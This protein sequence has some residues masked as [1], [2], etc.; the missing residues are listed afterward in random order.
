MFVI[1]LFAVTAMPPFGVFLSELQVIRAMGGEGRWVTMGLFLVS[2]LMAFVGMTRVVFGIVDG[3]T[4]VATKG[5]SER[6]RESLGVVLPPLILLI[7]SLG[8]GLWT[9]SV[10]H[11]TWIHAVS[12]LFPEVGGTR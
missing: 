6:F 12:E 7:L 2:L 8:L 3:P 4:R 10:L 1:G 9:P 5:G 11:E